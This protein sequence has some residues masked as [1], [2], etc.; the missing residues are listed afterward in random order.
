[1]YNEQPSIRMTYIATDSLPLPNIYFRHFYNFAIDCSLSKH[2]TGDVYDDCT[3]YITATKYN[4]G[5]NL[6]TYSAAFRDNNVTLPTNGVDFNLDIYITDPLYNSSNQIDSMDIVAFDKEFD[7]YNMDTQDFGD[8]RLTYYWKFTRTIKY[9]LVKDLL[10][11]FGKPTYIKKPYID[12]NMQIVPYTATSYNRSDYP[13]EIINRNRTFYATLQ[14]TPSSNPIVKVETEQ[15]NKTVLSLLGI[16]GGIWSAMAAFY[17]FLFGFGLIS[18]WGFV[19]KSRPFKDQYKKNLLM[20]TMDLQFDKL[21]EI[22]KLSTE[23]YE[24]SSSQKRLNDLEKQVEHL[25]KLNQFYIKFIIDTSFL[26][27]LKTDSLPL[28]DTE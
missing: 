5:D 10:S 26:N 18:P 21:D 20:T 1:M 6:Y 14:F 13:I 17:V 23:G 2:S 16:L 3:K 24:N 4:S 28:L 8:D 15:R 7:N 27:S 25:K 19:H 11:Y 22:K 12:T 9:S